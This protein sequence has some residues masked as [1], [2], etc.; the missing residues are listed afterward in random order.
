MERHP[1]H[2]TLL[3]TAPGTAVDPLFLE[4]DLPLVR[5]GVSHTSVWYFSAQVSFE[6]NLE[7]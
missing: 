4:V 3:Q 5:T 7:K 1:Y 2:E 6:E